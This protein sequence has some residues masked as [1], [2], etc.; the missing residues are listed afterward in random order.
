MRR[1]DFARGE[2]IVQLVGDVVLACEEVVLDASVRATKNMVA[3]CEDAIGIWRDWKLCRQVWKP[4][5][6]D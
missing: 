1:V 4:S 3:E 5:R 2:S 6:W